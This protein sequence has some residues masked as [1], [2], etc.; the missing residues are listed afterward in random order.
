MSWS[1][2]D[3]QQYWEEKKYYMDV[4]IT[5][6]VCKKVITHEAK[7]NGRPFIIGKVCSDCNATKVIPHRLLEWGR[8]TLNEEKNEQ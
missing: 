8:Q 4:D 5:C 2:E 7:H 1:Y 3:E 6:D